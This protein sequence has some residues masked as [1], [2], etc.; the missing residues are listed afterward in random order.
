MFRKCDLDHQIVR[1]QKEEQSQTPNWLIKIK[2]KM[3]QQNNLSAN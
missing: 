1:V 3:K 2:K